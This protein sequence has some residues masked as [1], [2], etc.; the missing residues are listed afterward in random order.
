MGAQEPDWITDRA[1]ALVFF[2][3]VAGAALILLVAMARLG[4][5]FAEASFGSVIYSVPASTWLGT[6]AALATGAALGAVITRPRIGALVSGVSA[7]LL[8][9][10]F[11]V[12][13]AGAAYHAST[14]EGLTIAIHAGFGAGIS[15]YYSAVAL[16]YV[17]HGG[18]RHGA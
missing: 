13:S 16:R 7:L 8:G 12:F 14:A 1:Q 4:L 15:A 9:V 18:R 10:T 5:H 3:G 11:V 17:C 2:A 6:Q